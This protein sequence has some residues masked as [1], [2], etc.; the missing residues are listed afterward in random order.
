MKE[1]QVDTDW[2]KNTSNK[3]LSTNLSASFLLNKPPFYFQIT[4][5]DFEIWTFGQQTL[6]PLTPNRR[7]TAY[8]SKK[9][10]NFCLFCIIQGRLLDMI[11]LSDNITSTEFYSNWEDDDSSNGSS[12]I[13][14]SS[15]QKNKLN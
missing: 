13:S 12:R 2:Q 10:V 7:P 5:C 8:F 14:I 11:Y 6:E 15:K 1:R 3:L 9:E 4:A